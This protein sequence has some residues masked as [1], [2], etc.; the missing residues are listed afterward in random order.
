MII[1]KKTLFLVPVLCGLA[2]S[3]PSGATGYGDYDQTPLVAPIWSK[4]GG[5]TYGRWAAEWWQWVVGVPAEVNPLLDADGSNCAQRQVGD[6]WFLAGS[7]VGEVT[8]HCQIP[9]GTSV[10]FPLVNRFNAAYLSDPPEE[11]TEEFV[12]EK[13]EC[14]VPA[15]IK[16]SID[17]RRVWKPTRFFTGPSGSQSP[18]FNVQM[19]PENL[20]FALYGQTEVDIPEWL[21]SPSAEQGYYLFVTRLAPGT[22][23]IEWRATGCG[24]DNEQIVTYILEVTDQ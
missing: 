12:R 20:L 15:R 8:R 6:V 2:A 19:P 23:T 7:W 10:F 21:L 4:P 14:T 11:R 9:A 18:M 1:N 5:Q 16:V 24:E 22:H 3:A 17:G 13:A